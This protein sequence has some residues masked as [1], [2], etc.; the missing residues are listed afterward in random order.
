M[1]LLQKGMAQGR[2]RLLLELRA[3]RAVAATKAAVEREEKA[4]PMEKAEIATEEVMR[5][6]GI[7]AL[8]TKAG[9]ERSP[10]LCTP[11]AVAARQRAMMFYALLPTLL[12][13]CM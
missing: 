12:K 3:A 11:S 10:P 9:S 8:R 2:M 13:G 6:K 1:L 5:M 4:R 7:R